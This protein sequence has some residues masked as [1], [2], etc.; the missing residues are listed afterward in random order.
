MAVAN[1]AAPTGPS[2]HTQEADGLVPGS[3]SLHGAICHCE[4]LRAPSSLLG[5]RN[6]WI[7]KQQLEYIRSVAGALVQDAG[8][9]GIA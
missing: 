7:Q 6:N 8:Q 4:S 5:V 1:W 9:S 2:P 3:S